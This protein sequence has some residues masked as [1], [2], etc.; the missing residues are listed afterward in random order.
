[1]PQKRAP[2]LTK[3]D[4]AVAEALHKSSIGSGIEEA[5][6]F[7]EKV[8]TS[9]SAEDFSRFITA[10]ARADGRKIYDYAEFNRGMDIL[11]NI[12]LGNLVYE[13]ALFFTPQ[14]LKKRRTQNS[15]A[16]IPADAAPSCKISKD[17]LSI[18][19]PHVTYR[20]LGKLIMTCKWARGNITE[21]Q[22][23]RCKERAKN[24]IGKCIPIPHQRFGVRFRIY[25]LDEEAVEIGLYHPESS[26][27]VC[28][29]RG[30]D[31]IG[32]LGSHSILKLGK[33]LK[34]Y[35]ESFSNG[36]QHMDQMHVA[37]RYYHDYSDERVMLFVD[38]KV[39]NERYPGCEDLEMYPFF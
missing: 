5:K 14:F 17:L 26:V 13:F 33:T 1:M 32:S 21:E 29:V 39:S 19:I 38:T 24:L 37:F 34:K 20:P 28:K 7:I 22:V 15:L 27:Y 6:T 31:F 36:E 16:I 9:L 18:I 3:A 25:N 10:M 30:K 8:K 23:K 4:S 2:K 11:E 35:H 12:S